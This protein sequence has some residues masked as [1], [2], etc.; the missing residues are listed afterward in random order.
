[1][2]STGSDA[3]EEEEP[4]LD[5]DFRVSVLPKRR[6]SK[7]VRDAPAPPPTFH[8]GYLDVSL[9]KAKEILTRPGMEKG[10]FMVRGC[11]EF[12]GQREVNTVCAGVDTEPR[13]RRFKLDPAAPSRTIVSPSIAK[14]MPLEKVMESWGFGDLAGEDDQPDAGGAA[15]MCAGFDDVEPEFG[16]LNAHIYEDTVQ[17]RG[18]YE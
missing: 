15:E 8:S 18:V 17:D 12:G 16:F 2:H 14:K 10:S 11:G 6:R 1:M 4:L 5:F 13:M 3:E 7:P 9:E